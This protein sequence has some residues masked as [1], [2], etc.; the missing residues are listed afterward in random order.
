MTPAKITYLKLFLK[1]PDIKTYIN[2]RVRYT[3]LNADHR[4]RKHK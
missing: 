3:K 2:K 1:N 4:V